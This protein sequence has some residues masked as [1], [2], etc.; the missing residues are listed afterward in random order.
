MAHIDVSNIEYF[1]LGLHNLFSSFAI[2]VEKTRLYLTNQ[3]IIQLEQQG[4]SS[5]DWSHVFIDPDSII[6]IR[7]CR[8][9]PSG[10]KIIV[11]EQRSDTGLCFNELSMPC[12]LLNCGFYGSCYIGD[13][14]AISNTSCLSNVIIGRSTAIV[15]CGQIKGY[16]CSYPGDNF[17][18]FNQISVGS[19]SG[20]RNVVL[21]I[22]A[23]FYDICRSVYN[24]QTDNPIEPAK[25]ASPYTVI[26]PHCRILYCLSIDS[27]YIDEWTY[28]SN[29]TISYSTIV[30]TPTSKVRIMNGVDLRGGL[31][32]PGCVLENGCYVENTLMYEHSSISTHARV[33]DSILGP[34]ASVAG[35]ECHRCLVGPFIGFHHHSLLIASLWPLGRGNIGYG[36]KVGA[37]HTGRVNDQ[38]CWPGEGCFFGLGCSI[39]FPV[40]LVDSPYSI[41]AP[42][43]SLSPQLIRFPCSLITAMTPVLLES[44]VDILGRRGALPVDCAVIKPAWVLHGNP[45][46]IDRLAS[47]YAPYYS[48]LSYLLHIYASVYIYVYCPYNRAA[49][50]LT[51]RRRSLLIDTSFPAI[52]PSLI[53]KMV[54]ARDR[55]LIAVASYP[56]VFTG[57][58]PVQSSSSEEPSLYCTK[59]YKYNK[60]HNPSPSATINNNIN[61]TSSASTPLLKDSYEVYLTEKEVPGLGRCVVSASDV[62]KA[63]DSYNMHIRRYALH[64]RFILYILAVCVTYGAL[65]ILPICV[66]MHVCRAYFIR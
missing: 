8:F 65:Y 35:G 13:N 18:N 46:M 62:C 61:N 48:N 19:E 4:N 54:D 60:S 26:R 24:H 51:T 16:N 59:R 22:F 45:Y 5:D 66:F 2:D 14:C 6:S 7:G 38:E 29:S 28:I 12:G 52:R 57:I 25:I 40:N 9:S 10:G 21:S 53:R 43:T 49:M 64:V 50:K 31:V 47:D 15:G 23:S 34:D 33:C 56:H 1:I 58:T 11:E 27:S 3:A 39:K 20:G 42:D 44:A 37:N 63:V 41:I 36:A 17:G 55:L 30:T 32:H